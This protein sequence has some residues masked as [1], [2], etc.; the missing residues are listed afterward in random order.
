MKKIILIT[1]LLST[2]ANPAFAKELQCAFGQFRLPYIDEQTNSGITVELAKEALKRT[3]DVCNPIYVSNERLAQLI[4]NGKVD[5]SFEVMP[6]AKNVF[7]SDAFVDYHNFA[8][9]KKKDHLKINSFEDL[10]DKSVVA[11]QHATIDNGPD[12]AASV[13]KNPNYTETPSQEN[14]VK[15]FLSGRSNV[16]IIGDLVLKYWAAVAKKDPSVKVTNDDLDFEFH[17]I[18]PDGGYYHDKGIIS[19]FVGFKDKDLRDKFNQALK[20]MR[21]DGSYDRIVN[22]TLK[23]LE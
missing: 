13:A 14:Q 4:N 10:S 18:F 21:E 7:Y 11:W 12:Y 8:I 17:P 23:N 15:L 19:F 9:T 22:T 20:A 1:L 3:G 5:A 2:F 16:A 6:L